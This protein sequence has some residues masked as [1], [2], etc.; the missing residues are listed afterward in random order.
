MTPLN[1][2][3]YSSYDYGVGYIKQTSKSIRV[4]FGA[5]SRDLCYTYFAGNHIV[6]WARPPPSNSNIMG[7][8][9]DKIL[10]YEALPE[11][12]KP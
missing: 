4:Y 12:P 9:R 3:K 10:H 11:V 8:Y 6:G 1:E 2:F 7:R 5:D